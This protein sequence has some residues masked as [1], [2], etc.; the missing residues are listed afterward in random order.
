LLITLLLVSFLRYTTDNLGVINATN[1]TLSEQR[2][3][4]IFGLAF[5]RLSTLARASLRDASQSSSDSPEAPLPSSRYLP[6][7]LETLTTHPYLQYPLFALALNESNP[8]LSIG[9]V[10]SNYTSPSNSTDGRR[11]EDIDWVQVV[12]FGPAINATRENSLAPT[13]VSSSSR[14]SSTS[15]SSAGASSS[16]T[17]QQKKRAEPTSLEE[18]EDEAYL[19]WAVQ[20][21]N[22]SVSGITELSRADLAR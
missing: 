8:S 20:L 16:S 22:I 9:G 10:S 5:P 14:S 18:L 3:S 1:I 4:G 15:A 13:R 2:I 19:Y 12:P 7:I 11:V 21:R 17:S 6:P